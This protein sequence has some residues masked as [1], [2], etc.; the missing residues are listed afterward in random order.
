MDRRDGTKSLYF[1]IVQRDMTTCWH[2]MLTP[3]AFALWLSLRRSK[4]RRDCCT[5]ADPRYSTP[6]QR[7]VLDRLEGLVVDGL[8]HG[9]FDYS[10]TRYFEWSHKPDV[11]P[12][13]A[14]AVK[15]RNF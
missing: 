4:T 5:M 7:E 9:F 6:F 14:L 2:S 15:H 3:S 11:L 13:L 1:V 10:A 12:A 8:K